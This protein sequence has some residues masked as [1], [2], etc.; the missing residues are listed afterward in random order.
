[1]TRFQWLLIAVIA[2]EFAAGVYLAGAARSGSVPPLPDLSQVDSITAGEIREA[3]ERCRTAEQWGD[4]GE[5]YLATGFFPEAETCYRHASARA[6]ATADLAFKHAFALE[7]LGRAEE[8]NAAYERAIGLNHRRRADCWYYVGRNHLRLEREDE[9]VA[10]FRQAGAIPGARLELALHDARAGRAA[11]AEAEARRL[12]DE[13]PAAYPPTSLRYRLALAGGD[14]AAADALADQFARR[15][16][17]LPTP[18]DTEVDWVFG[19]ANRV[20]QNRLFAEAGRDV[21][22]GRPEEAEAK[23]RAALDAGWSPEIADRLA[24]VLF[25]LG[26]RE[27]AAEVLADAVA[28]GRP[29]FELLWR[30][31]QARDA[32]GQPGTTLELWERASRVATGPATTDLWHDLATRYDAVGNKERAKACR[33]RA[34]LAAAI[35]SL[36]AGKPGEAVQAFTQAVTNDSDLARAWYWLG[37]GERAAGRPDAARSAYERCLL[38]NP[39]EGRARRSLALLTD[40]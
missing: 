5:I 34:Y 23:L 4:L 28:R 30:L 3:A 1:V 40:R 13:F 27:Q 20:G 15:P 35:G 22:A 6:P 25:G 7:R 24:E 38:L 11:E 8:A 37:E 14:R 33:A 10:A 12:S 2:A 9:A 29:S 21:Q 17:P 26:K 39:D 31:G 19:V 36:D 16:R 32:I 18:F